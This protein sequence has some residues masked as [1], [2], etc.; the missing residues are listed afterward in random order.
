MYLF[1][2]KESTPWILAVVAIYL[3]EVGRVPLVNSVNFAQVLLPET[4]KKEEHP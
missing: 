4:I 2:R 3:P 1:E